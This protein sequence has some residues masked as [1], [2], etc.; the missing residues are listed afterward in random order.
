MPLEDFYNKNFLSNSE[1]ETLSIA[2]SFG[3]ELEG[4]EIILLEG[5]LGAG[6]TI[7]VKGL[8]EGAGVENPDE[9]NSPSFTILNIYHGK[10]PIYH[11]DLYRVEDDPEIEISDFIGEGVVVI[12]WAD[13]LRERLEGISI[14]IEIID[15]T[16]RRIKI[17][18]I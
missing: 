2:K 14:K 18:L 13:R 16:K 7:F 6:K 1:E 11:F 17:S 9:V 12:E 8:A 3:R 5:E 4:R 15:E 10:F